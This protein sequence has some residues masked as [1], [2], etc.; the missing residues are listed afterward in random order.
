MN[1][2]WGYN[3]KTWLFYVFGRWIFLS[4]IAGALLQFLLSDHFKIH[5]IPAFLLNQFILANIFWFIDKAI[6]KSHFRI[7]KFFLLWEIR[8]N[9]KCA[10]CGIT[11]EGYRIVKTHR[12]DRINDPDPEFR[13]KVCRENKMKE[14]KERNML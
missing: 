3:M 8:D 2:C 9:V 4:G 5:T 7:P 11:C 10:D 6:F 14:L 13:C 12:Y 1:T